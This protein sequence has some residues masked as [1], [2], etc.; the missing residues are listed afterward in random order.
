MAK[1]TYSIVEGFLFSDANYAD[2]AKKE[3]ESV[4]LIRRKMDTGNPAKVL[5]LYQKMIE[6]RMF[7]TP[8]GYAFLLEIQEYLKS[9]PTINLSEISAIPVSS[10]SVDP[11]IIKDA[12]DA[13]S[14]A[15]EEAAKAELD[16][17][18]EQKGIVNGSAKE[19]EQ[20][21]TSP[22]SV[23]KKKDKNNKSGAF[24]FSVFLNVILALIVIGMFAVSYTAGSTNILN[25][26][27]RIVNKY[28]EW[29]LEL[30]EREEALKAREAQTK[31]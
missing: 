2:R 9:K 14:K 26:E 7:Q 10:P 6:Q 3:A 8:V 29:E 11:S 5:N 15:V 23:N 12:F 13:R 22:K 25:Y 31:E 18:D 4:K 24:G 21:N 27:E 19:V 28:A 16:K 30:T 1:Q 20:E 17:R